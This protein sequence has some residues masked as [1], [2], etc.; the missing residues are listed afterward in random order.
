MDITVSLVG[1]LV[2]AQFP[3]WAALAIEPV[4]LDGWDNR[5]FRLGEHMAVRLPGAEA[6]AG[7]VE[8][9]RLGFPLTV[10]PGTGRS[11][12]GSKARTRPLSV[13]TTCTAEWQKQL[14]E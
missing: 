2:A 10:F 8:K 7:Q 4:E 12:T 3:R 11:T 9:E 1:Q 6:Y 14:C 13:S 5:T